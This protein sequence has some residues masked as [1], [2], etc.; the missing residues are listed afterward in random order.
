MAIAA[1]FD[2]NAGLLNILGDRANDTIAVTRNAAGDI[3]VNGGAVAVQGGTPT[4][5]NTGLI[6]ASGAGG[7][8]A[9]DASKL[10]EG[11]IQ[12]VLDGGGGNDTIL[13][14]G[15]KDTLRGGGG[16]DFIDGNQGNDVA[17]LGGGN[18]TFQWDPG[19]GSD[20]VEGQG[21][22]DTMLF[23]GNNAAENVDISANGG[24]VRFF[25]DAANITMDLN[26]VEIIEFNAQGGADNITVGDLSGTD[27]RLVAIDLAAAGGTAGDD[28]PDSV[29][30]NGSNGNNSISV[31]LVGTAVSVNGLRPQVTIDHAEATDKLT[32]NGLGGNDTINASKLP[33]AA[34]QLVLDGGAGNDTIIGSAGKDTIN[35]GDGNDFIDGNQGDD[36][37]L[38]GA[39]NDVFQWD[40]GDGSDVVEG[41]AGVDTM[42]FNGAN[43]SENI[44]IAANG[45]RVRFFRDV[46]NITMDLN[47]VERIEFRALGGE[48]NIVVGDLTGTD[49]AEV[50]ID[51]AATI[52][53]RAG[54]GKLDTVTVN[55]TN[56]TDVITVASTGNRI[57]VEGLTAEVIVDHADRTDLLVINGLSGSDVIDAS[58][59]AANKIALQVFGGLGEDVIIGSAGNDTVNGGDGNDVAILGAGND[60]FIW[61]PGDD[62]DVVEGRAG[63][64]TMLFNGA[65]IANIAENVD[66]SANGG[67]VRFFRDV[68]NVTM[69]LNDVETIEFTAQGGVDNIT[70]GD[71]SGTDAKLVAIDLAATGGTTGDGQ[72]DSVIVNG[73]NGNNNINVALVGTEVSVTGLPARVT[74]DHA[75]AADKLTVNGLDG[76]DTINASKLPA[77]AIQL[78]LDG[79]AGNDTITGSAGNDIISGGSGN[80]RIKGGAGNDSVLY[81]S[82]LD[83]LDVIDGFDGDAAGGQ[84][85]LDLDALFDG[86]GVTAADRAARVSVVDNGGSVNVAVDV[87]GNAANG[88]EVVLAT[89]NTADAITIGQD[90]LVG[91]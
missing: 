68:A 89:L 46:A 66:I 18:D 60:L 76:N 82:P 64:D 12:M 51:L 72:P 42:L 83:G 20:L 10:V 13:G 24:R 90:V 59:L 32:V 7:N 26:D 43:A 85:T 58:G 63:I 44:D 30:V 15:G 74:I 19:D 50:E 1:S 54:D 4:V 33:A 49:A 52:N 65:N 17:L 2:P 84:D 53:G 70:V 71:L 75:E 31:A 27:T 67:R 62:N 77:A 87:D 29:I 47:D 34:I 6:Q 37:A 48:D 39:G 86:L 57:T 80:D 21:G 56:N 78:V 45:E 81:S 69:D 61:N 79:G 36:L 38:L 73:S 91:S 28:Q 22:I 41:Q 25:R 11:A 23:N 35:G 3:L 14:G 16:N 55:G 40:P 88:F 5:A 8:D 9:I